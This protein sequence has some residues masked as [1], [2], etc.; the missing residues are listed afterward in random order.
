MFHETGTPASTAKALSAA[1]TE[2]AQEAIAE[3][4]RVATQ[5]R[6]ASEAKLKKELG[7]EYEPHKQLAGRVVRTYG[8][9]ELIDMLESTVVNGQKL[10]D[11]PEMVR[12]FG[13]LGRRMDE[14]G[15]IGAASA[16]EQQ[17][18]QEELNQVMR[19]NPPGTDKYRDP[20][21]QKRI[22]ELNE[23]LHGSGPVV[24]QAG[25]AN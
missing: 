12:L 20:T 24:G 25:R 9:P 10:G 4:E 6:E 15:F 5:A 23:K 19:D 18:I 7:S 2:M 3:Q 11:H 22:R 1:V 16:D 14:H 17:S 21:V 13:T 8:S